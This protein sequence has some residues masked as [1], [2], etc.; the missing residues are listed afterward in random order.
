MLN[1][2]FVGCITMSLTYDARPDEWS[3][4]RMPAWC[5]TILAIRSQPPGGKCMARQSWDAAVMELA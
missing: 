1:T 3:M 5:K 2:R 4:V